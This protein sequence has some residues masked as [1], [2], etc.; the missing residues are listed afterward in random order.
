MITARPMEARAVR[1]KLSCWTRRCCRIYR[2]WRTES[3][4]GHV[5]PTHLVGGSVSDSGP[6]GILTQRL[7]VQGA[8]DISIHG[9]MKE[10]TTNDK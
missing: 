5:A 2:R 1:P 8:L 9:S 10:S 4:A 7:D 3:R 6:L